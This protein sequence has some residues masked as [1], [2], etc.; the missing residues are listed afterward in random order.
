MMLKPQDLLVL[1]KLT[2]IEGEP[3]TYASLADSVGLSTS[4]THASIKRAAKAG[5]YSEVARSAVRPALGK[6]LVGGAAF[7]YYAAIGPRTR[8]GIRTGLA[9]PVLEGPEGVPEDALYV[10][11]DASGTDGGHVVE[12]LYKSVPHAARQDP[13]LYRL[14]AAFDELRIGR[15]RE[16]ERAEQLLRE[17]LC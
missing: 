2:A 14:L 1:L 6:L 3:W 4:E 8:R 15:A 7:V 10:W 13:A 17:A 16:R 5:L 9:A 11:P 12:P